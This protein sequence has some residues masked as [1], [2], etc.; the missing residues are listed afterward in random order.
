MI[1]EIVLLTLILSQVLPVF[2]Y[3]QQT[4]VT[5]PPNQMVTVNIVEKPQNLELL[6]LYVQE[7]KV[8]NKSQ[9]ESLFIPSDEINR[10]IDYL[11]HYG[12]QASAYMNVIT[13]TGKASQF[14]RA[15]GGEFYLQR[16]HNLTFYEYLGADSPLI[17]NAEVFSTNVTK[18]LLQRPTTLYNVSQAVA[19]SLVN[20]KQLQEAYNVSPLL[21][22][23]IN[24][25][26]V[27]IGIIDFYGD[28]YIQSQ[29]A[30]FDKNYN[31][32][33]PPSFQVQSIGAYNPNDGISTGWALEIS[34]DVE[35]SHVLA[36]NA[37][38]ILYVANPNES[39]PAIIAYIDS[40]DKVSVVS[41]SFG[42]PEIYVALGLLPLSMIQSMTYEYWLGEVEGITFVASSGDGGGTGNNF[43]LSPLGNLVLPASDPYVLSVGGTTL[44]FSNGTSEQTAWSGESIFGASTGGYS[45]IFPSPWYQGTSGFRLVPDVSADGNPYTGVPVTYYYNTS[46]LVGGTSLASPLVSAIIALAVQVH[47]RLGFINPLIYSLNGTKALVPINYGYNTPFVAQG[48][49][50]PVTGLG[51]INAGYFVNLLN[52]E[53]INSEKSVSVA[54]DNTTYLDGQVAKVVIKAPPFPQPSVQIFNGSGM[55]GT[56][57]VTYNGSYWVG[58]FTATGDGVQEIL[59]SQGNHTSGAYFTSGLQAQFLLPQVALYPTP[60]NL[61]VLVQLTYPNGTIAHSKLSFSAFLYKYDPTTGSQRLI[62]TVNL[63]HPL[64]LNFTQFGL[65]VSNATNYV[66]GSFPLNSSMVNGI[67]LVEISGAYGFD[68]FVSGI[69]VVPYIIPGIATEPLTL[70]PGENFTLAVFT[71]TLGSP[72][73][74]VTFLRNGTSA[75]NVTVNSIETSSGQLYVLETSLPDNFTPGYYTVVAKATYNFSN[76]TAGGIGVTQIYVAPRSLVL[77]LNNV[78]ETALQNSTL[79]INATID[80]PNGTPVKYGTFSAIVIPSYLQGSFDNLAISNAVPLQYE[81]GHWIGYFNL[82]SG[83]DSNELGLS[84]YGLAGQWQIYVSG[85]ASDGYPTQTQSSLDYNTLSVV[86]SPVK[87]FV[88]LPYVLVPYFNGTSGYNLYILNATI[89]NHNATLVNSVIY[90]L[91]AINST[92]SLLN[93]Q[94]F[95]YS[96]QNSTL[97]NNTAITPVQIL[98][99]SNHISPQGVFTRPAVEA[100]SSANPIISISVVIVGVLV[101]IYVW[102]RGRRT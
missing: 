32:S 27:T 25:T 98:T 13:A 4:Q 40:Q 86:P 67:Y 97:L 58:T 55:T 18:T 60:G 71:E 84:P 19:F 3:N 1:K 83:S 37:G 23:G 38:L 66:F 16:F 87:T 77:S 49:P 44:Y 48:S 82:P 91:T 101:L 96:L 15:L 39:L 90:N 80:Y 93:T 12:I 11:H 57:P 54:V 33:P 68:E 29:L 76:Y 62:S 74:T 64:V 75:Y 85:V 20:P 45:V 52:S 46:V 99:S 59:V 95:H 17:Q 6:Q 14:E 81:G 26:N 8:L 41:Q 35:Y 2:H 79:E 92:V 94:V 70:A 100:K 56:V 24:G 28:P 9:V 78:E 42:I 21:R 63:T 65:T 31:L 43:F 51:Y 7:H 73:V 89:V 61:P 34:L 22:Q 47:G 50:N 5:L 88:L 30:S 102:I 69:Y 10:T 72:N 53:L 36:P